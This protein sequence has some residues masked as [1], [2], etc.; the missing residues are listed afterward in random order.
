MRIVVISATSSIAEQCIRRWA[1]LGDHE[2]VLVGRNA[3]KLRILE[4]SLTK[5]FLRSKFESHTLD[6]SQPNEIKKLSS[7]L[8]VLPADVVL[9]AQGSATAQ[10]EVQGN[11]E[12]F[13]KELQLNAVSVAMFAE[14]FAEVL[15][16]QGF[17]SL[18]L[19]GSVAGDRGR[20]YNYSYGAAKALI[21]ATAQGLQQRLSRANVFVSLVKPGPTATPMTQGHKGKF[22]SPEKVARVI[23]AGV[24][25]RKRVIYAPRRWR[26]IMFIVRNIPFFI[27]RRFR[28]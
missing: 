9:I 3:E 7:K 5:S 10:H 18:V 13:Q 2:F 12:Y 14:S 27:F 23:V 19:I 25:N 17:G 8:S 6:F 21:E 11:L 26:F 1:S 28:F 24:A 4:T 15:E 20:A 22:T 16:T